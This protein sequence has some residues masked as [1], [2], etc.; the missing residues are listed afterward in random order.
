[1]ELSPPELI[2]A[3]RR[4][5][6]AADGLRPAATEVRGQPASAFGD[7]VRQSA[8]ACAVGW[9]DATGRVADRVERCADGLRHTARLALSVDADVAA[10]FDRLAGRLCR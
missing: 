2:D 10:S 5:S 1:M 8:L 7:G 4:W 6:G 3:A 9:G